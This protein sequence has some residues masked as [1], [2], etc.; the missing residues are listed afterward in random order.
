[1]S[2]GTTIA[3]GGDNDTFVFNSSINGAVVSLDA[4]A[5]SVSFVTQVASSTIWGGGSAA[6][7]TVAFSGA[8]DA[9]S[10]DGTI[11]AGSIMG[12]SGNDQ[13]VF[14]SGAANIATSV[15]KLDAGNDTL[16][17][18]SNTVLGEFGLGAGDDSLSATAM[19]VGS[20]AVSFWGGSGN[21]TFNIV[22]AGGS[23][24]AYFWN[25]AGTDSIVLGGAI[26]TASGGAAVVFGVTN[27]ASMNISFAAN[28]IA[29][30]ATSTFGAGTMSSSWQVANSNLVSF[31]FGSTMT[32]IVFT[33]G[34]A[35][36]LPGWCLRVG[37][38][39]HDLRHSV[40]INWNRSLR[41]RCLYPNLQLIIPFGIIQWI[42]YAPSQE[43]LFLC[44]F[45]V[46]GRLE[47]CA[48]VDVSL[49]KGEVLSTVWL[50]FF[51]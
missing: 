1:M 43:G 29:T 21:D 40:G 50:D 46:M 9:A 16:V 34:G 5:D 4:G 42:I 37:G 13:F 35:A 44:I 26:S 22:S 32:T 27:N 20:S 17:F 7:Q 19:T 41:Y 28:A 8:A 15:V 14:L 33:G 51:V 47:N 3:G 18:N 45:Q 30:S 10:F 23:G 11:G 24:T 2:T 6:I 38:R 49:T 48:V 31:G 36:T 12:G 39:N 25:E